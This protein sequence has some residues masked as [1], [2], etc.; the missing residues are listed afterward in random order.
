MGMPIY[1]ECGGLIYLCRSLTY[2]E[3]AYPMAG[4]FPIDLEMQ[5]KPVGHGYVEAEVASENTFLSVGTLLRGHEFHYS[6]PVGESVGDTCLSLKSGTGLGKQRDGL[7][8]RNVFATYLHLHAD[9]VPEW[10]PGL[11]TA[12]RRYRDDRGARSSSTARNGDSSDE[13]VVSDCAPLATGG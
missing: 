2:G 13:N 4:V 7:A 5:T 10:A 8:Y 3:R 12:A 11:V 9:G 1:A 6:R